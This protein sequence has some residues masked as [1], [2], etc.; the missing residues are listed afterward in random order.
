MKQSRDV[1]DKGAG[2]SSGGGG[3]E[4]Q[5]PNLRLKFELT[6]CLKLSPFT[7]DNNLSLSSFLNTINLSHSFIWDDRS[8]CSEE[9][10]LVVWNSTAL[11]IPRSAIHATRYCSIR[12][13]LFGDRCWE[14]PIED[15]SL[16]LK[17]QLIVELSLSLI[18]FGCSRFGCSRIEAIPPL[19][20]LATWG[21]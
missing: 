11:R 15:P 5:T 14:S 18:D 10:T 6:K 21:F 7:F 1:R 3:G 16:L 12:H 19:G 13:S 17:P 8:P 4:D 2:G 9:F 20:L